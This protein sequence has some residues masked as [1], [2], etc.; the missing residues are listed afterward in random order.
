MKKI[1]KKSLFS[2][3]VI[4]PLT[5]SAIT[6]VSCGSNDKD[7]KEWNDFVAAAK[8]ATAIEIVS[9]ANPPNWK[10]LNPLESELSLT[11]IDADDS[12][13][14]VLATIQYSKNHYNTV[15]GTFSIDY[16]KGVAYSV[17][18]WKTNSADAPKENPA[19]QSWADFSKAAQQASASAIV[20]NSGMAKWKDSLATAL[21]LKKFN[22]DDEKETISTIITNSSSHATASFTITYNKLKYNINQW[23]YNNDLS[24]IFNKNSSIPIVG[25]V[26]QITKID[27]T[28]YVGTGI[29]IG[30]GD[31]LWSS[32]N[33][34]KTFVKNS[35]IPK[36]DQIN[37]IIKI[38]DTIYVGTDN[39]LYSSIDSGK[40]FTKNSSLP[41]NIDVEQ[42]IKT[43]DNTIL[44]STL[45][46]GLYSS[47]NAG[48]T[49]NINSS[50]PSN[51]GINQMIKIAATIYIG[52]NDEGGLY[53]S[54]DNGHSFTKNKSLPEKI[55]ITQVIEINNIIYS[56]S[57]LGLW[58][59]GDNAKTFTKNSSLPNDIQ[60]SK[61]IKIN[62]NTILLATWEGLYS[63]IDSGKTFSK[64]SFIPSDGDINDVIKIDNTIYIGIYNKGL[65]SSVD[66][67]KTFSQ[68]SSIPNNID[69]KIIANIDNKAYIG[70][71]KGLYS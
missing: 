6:V 69:V 11:S 53:S 61:I 25:G 55:S 47:T 52:T 70:T 68:N 4:L 65:W 38:D 19:E 10:S 51:A 54:V 46:Q 33:G 42:M 28:I 27:N 12:S 8:K 71:D 32:T 66:G 45:G 5:S 39:G 41:N 57:D 56:G 17:T 23:K 58:S 14:S 29:T 1:I 44:L 40:T 3:G 36:D 62:N 43:N 35:S 37:Q 21:S 26:S 24:I 34:G 18:D 60:I 49:F 20:H 22:V 63:S 64:N 67:G 15:S 50:L 13:Q 30:Y 2:L 31:G 9:N 7:S 48:K 16:D 59:S